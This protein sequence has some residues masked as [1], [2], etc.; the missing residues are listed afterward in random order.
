[1]SVSDIREKA[2]EL[3]ELIE[4][5]GTDQ[6]TRR[7]AVRNVGNYRIVGNLL[8][9]TTLLLKVVQDKNEA[10]TVRHA[11][12][13]ALS[14]FQG[15]HV[16]KALIEILKDDAEDPDL[17]ECIQTGISGC[18]S[19]QTKSQFAEIFTSQSQSETTRTRVGECLWN[20]LGD[21][22]S[23]KIMTVF[24]DPTE[25]LTIRKNAADILSFQ[26]DASVIDIL[27]EFLENKDAEPE[28]RKH[29]ACILDWNLHIRTDVPFQ[30]LR[31]G[32]ETVELRLIVL[33]SLLLSLAFEEE[34]DAI[35]ASALIEILSDQNEDPKI[36]S[37][38]CEALECEVLEKKFTSPEVKQ[39]IANYKMG[40]N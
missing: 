18:V 37:E 12:G 16:S 25:S 4:N 3:M 8:R 9:M 14:T 19:S 11:A 10:R 17:H 36:R 27:E 6:E 24:Q 5:T 40:M 39:A 26:D 28:L 32:N 31:D 2:D 30:I 22:G 21:D 34:D 33:R 20:P 38:V 23:Q 35:L 13:A 15:L 7:E 1:M 29:I